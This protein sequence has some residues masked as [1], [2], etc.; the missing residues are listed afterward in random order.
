M[1]TRLTASAAFN[2]VAWA[3]NAG[4]FALIAR[5]QFIDQKIK[6]SVKPHRFRLEASERAFRS[7]V[8][9]FRAHALAA[10]AVLAVHTCDAVRALAI[11]RFASGIHAGWARLAGGAVRRAHVVAYCVTLHAARVTSEGVFREIRPGPFRELRPGPGGDGAL[12]WA[13]CSG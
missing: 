6:P 5:A 11:G 10:V 2:T 9:A 3:G 13:V 8:K 4:P 12:E 1:P 7:I